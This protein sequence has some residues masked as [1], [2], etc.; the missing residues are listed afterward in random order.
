MRKLFQHLK[1]KTKL[2]ILIFLVFILAVVA[3]NVYI[4][5][6]VNK[7]Y[8]KSAK[9][10]VELVA[11]AIASSKQ[12]IDDIDLSTDSS[13]ADIQTYAEKVR[14]LSQVEFITIFD[15]HG[16][17]YSHPDKHKI[18]QFIM[19]GD[20]DRALRGESYFSVAQGTL[21]ISVRAFK[22]IFDANHTQIGAV[23]VG[24]TL[25][26]IDNVASRM[27]NPIILTLF[28]SLFIAILLALWLSRN[29]KNVLLGLEP[30]EMVK[31]FEERDAII[32]TVKE[33]IVVIDRQGKIKQI[34]AEAKRILKA[35]HHAH[36]IGK[37][38]C[39]LI[40]NT[41]LYD[42][43]LTG[44]PEY[45]NEQKID[46]IVI[47]TNRTP[48]IVNGELI[49]AVAT[50]RDMTEIRTMAENLTGV[51][52]YADA[53]RSQSH[54]FNNKL[55]VIYGLAF[56]DKRTELMAY[57]EDLIGNNLLESYS[58]EQ[59]IKEPILAG[60][61]NSK[62]SRAREL[63]VKLDFSI[64]GILL[65]INNTSNIHRLVTILGNLIDNGF[66]ALQFVENKQLEVKLTI[67]D[68][69]VHIIVKD[70]GPGIPAEIMKKIFNK[71]YSTKGD[72]R[73]FGLYLVLA[74]LDELG[75]EI[76]IH[77]EATQSGVCFMV[78]I[79]ITELY[80][81]RLDD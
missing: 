70:N 44:K 60:F 6:I 56:E 24:Q 53:L 39:N 46:G 8:Y 7:E 35:E 21:G 50:F 72:N 67:D 25:Q 77:N 32:H 19:G 68:V 57:L 69:Y 63:D 5:H 36:L 30:F 61:L 71:G 52:R 27:V 10:R 13:L 62:F 64:D 66:E 28:V 14:L 33:G 12:I 22:P 81:E 37:D 49:G 29:I 51:N 34:N 4:I 15:M 26:K 31:L 78:S 80:Q 75:G 23:M 38:V 42:V 48:L 9:Q 65:P 1:L 18:G 74:S 59:T 73:G 47:L 79:P 3:E 17:R 41:R 55:H 11:R 45:D 54:E 76:T 40:P 20:G 2:I 58:I 16:M 43:M